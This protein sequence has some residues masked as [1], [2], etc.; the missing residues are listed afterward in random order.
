MTSRRT[1]SSFA[2]S[3][4]KGAELAGRIGDGLVAVEPAAELVDAFARAPA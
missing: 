1:I 4:S 3:G 2:A